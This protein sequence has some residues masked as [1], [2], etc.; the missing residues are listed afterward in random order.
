MS[1]PYHSRE[2]SGDNGTG[3]RKLGPPPA[4]PSKKPKA[5]EKGSL[6][7]VNPSNAAQPQ[8]QRAAAIA[9]AA[10]TAAPKGDS[11]LAAVPPPA[12]KPVVKRYRLSAKGMVKR[13]EHVR[14]PLPA[15]P[16]FSLT[17]LPHPA[18]PTPR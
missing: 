11:R 8:A 18:L 13:L 2:P 12:A 5:K 1:A 3:S 9:A 7:A 4:R 6:V 15:I 16:A 17:L 10:A 14:L